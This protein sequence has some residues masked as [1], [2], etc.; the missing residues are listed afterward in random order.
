[1]LKPI[2]IFFIIAI[3]ASRFLPHPPNFTPIISIFALTSPA[4]VLPLLLVYLGTDLIIGVHAVMAWVYASLFAISYFRPGPLTSSIIFFIV[5]NFGVWT[6]GWYGFDIQ[7][8][9]ECYWV[10][11]PFFANTLISTFLFYNLYKFYINF[12]NYRLFAV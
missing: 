2:N 7:G 9:I 3:I 1:M 8:L 12:K 6:T 5:T 4:N 11:L 10:A